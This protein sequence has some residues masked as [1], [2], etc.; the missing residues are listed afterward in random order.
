MNNS[1]TVSVA[2]KRKPYKKSTIINESIA[3]NKPASVNIYV[4]K[5]M[6]YQALVKRK[7]EIDKIRAS[8]D[9]DTMP[10]IS[11]YVGD[12][13]QKICT[14]LARKYTFSGYHFRDDMVADAIVHCLRYIDSFDI[15]QSENPF[16]YFTQAAY[17]QFLARIESEKQYSYV[18][19]KSLMNSAIYDELSEHG[20]SSI[21]NESSSPQ[22]IEI[23]MEFYN[24]FVK[25][26]EAKL[27]SKGEASRERRKELPKNKKSLEYAIAID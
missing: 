2:P 1:E 13:I 14:N 10:K 12:C 25:D 26:F 19:A 15:T 17:Y 6:F 11:D 5:A 16:S 23:D 9:M 7:E 8:G 21:R 4:D 18:K 27:E 24:T 22:N 3:K 20:D